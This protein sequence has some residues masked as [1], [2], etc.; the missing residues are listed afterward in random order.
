VVTGGTVVALLG[1]LLVIAVLSPG[2][3]RRRAHGSQTT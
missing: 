1:L 3:F 2:A